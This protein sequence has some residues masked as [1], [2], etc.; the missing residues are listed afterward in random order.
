MYNHFLLLLHAKDD[1]DG[2]IFK[3]IASSYVYYEFTSWHEYIGRAD[4]FPLCNVNVVLDRISID[5]L[6]AL[7]D[8]PLDNDVSC[9]EYE[10]ERDI[11]LAALLRRHAGVRQLQQ[12]TGIGKNIISNDSKKYISRQD[13]VLSPCPNVVQMEIVKTNIDNVLI[14]EPRVF[15]DSRGYFFE[16]FSRRDFG[17]VLFQYNNEIHLANDRN[18]E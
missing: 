18:K 3:C 9:M 12:L 17:R 5:E 7:I 2:N 1:T 11:I 10:E 15:K 13:S 6:T 8:A 4:F 16:S 14:I